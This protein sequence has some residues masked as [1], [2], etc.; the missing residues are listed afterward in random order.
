MLGF[1]FSR[2]GVI[3]QV[4]AIVHFIRRR[5]D[6]YW[7]FII[8]AGGS[9]GA[10]AYI[11]LEILP[12]AGLLR[13]SFEVFPRRKRIKQLQLAILDNPSPG[14]YEELGDLYL[15]DGKFARARECLDKVIGSRVDSTDAYYRRALAASALQDFAAAAADL[16]EVY[17]REPR[18]DSYR[19][20][21]L[22]AHARGKIGQHEAAERLFADVTETCTLSEVQYDYACFL[23]DRG[24]DGEAA[25][26][27]RRILAKRPTMPAH[28]RRRERPW[29]RKATA[30][31]KRLNHK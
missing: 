9:I 22:L 18:Y 12:D 15:D 25:E 14:N 5:P 6:G 7:L 4:I 17:K 11:L 30:L 2:Y 3:L 1:L 28:I 20:A 23:A 27:A 24:R 21:G 13:G 29:F 8:M 31:L 26:W 19:A 16:E 10:A